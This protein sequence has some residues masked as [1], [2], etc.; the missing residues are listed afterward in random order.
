MC[1]DTN[2]GYKRGNKESN[3]MCFNILNGNELLL[4]KIVIENVI[5]YGH[6]NMEYSAGIRFFYWP[7]YKNNNNKYNHVYGRGVIEYNFGY[8]LSDWYIDCIYGSFNNKIAKFNISQWYQT[9]M[10]ADIKYKAWKKKHK[11]KLV[12]EWAQYDDDGNDLFYSNGDKWNDLYGIAVGSIITIYHLMS[13]LFYCNFS[14]QQYE[15]SA[16]FRRIYWNETDQALKKRH[17]YFANW[18]K[19]LRETVECFGI[20]MQTSPVKIFYHGISKEMVFKSTTIF[21]YGP[22]STTAGL[23]VLC[24]RALFGNVCF[25]CYRFR[26]CPWYLRENRWSSCGY[27]E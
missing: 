24:L 25:Y 27:L 13:I 3:I 2:N 18:A 23:F 22:L 15:L 6:K 20:P 4:N 14:I 8:I 11:Y 5:I 10:K 21:I 26:D 19:L 7:F 1:I 12:C 16:T 17:S 9:L